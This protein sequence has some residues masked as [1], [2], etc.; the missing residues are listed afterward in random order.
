LAL[1]IDFGIQ[2]FSINTGAGIVDKANVATV[3]ELAGK[4]R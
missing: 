2:P 3:A 4:V 1:F